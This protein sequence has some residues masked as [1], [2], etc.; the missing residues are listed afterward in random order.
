MGRGFGYEAGDCPVTESTSDRLVRLPLY[1]S[2]TSEDVDKVV[3]R[4]LTFG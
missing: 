4:A 1:T 3:A 2:I